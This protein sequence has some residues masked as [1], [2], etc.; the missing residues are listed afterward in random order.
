MYAGMGGQP[1]S[2]R[3][4]LG[5]LLGYPS[6]HLLVFIVPKPLGDRQGIYS[7]PLPPRPLRDTAVEFIVVYRA[8]WDHKLVADLDAKP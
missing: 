1:A 2:G 5:Y 4:L 7:L 6:G 8:Q 3:P